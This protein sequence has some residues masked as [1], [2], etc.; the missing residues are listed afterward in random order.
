VTPV[1]IVARA[2]DAFSARDLETIVNELVHPEIEVLP[3]AGFVIPH[4]ARYTGL[5]GVLEF[6]NE[7]AGDWKEHEVTPAELIAVDDENVLAITDVRLVPHSGE[8]MRL[9]SASLWTVEDGRITR[10]R[11]FPSVETARRAAGLPE[12]AG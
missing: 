5:R 10:L 4:H 9:Q 3:M 6:M 8:E 7:A 2:I 12:Q 1:E 11:G